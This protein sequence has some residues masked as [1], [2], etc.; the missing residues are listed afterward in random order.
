MAEII[1]SESHKK[2]R[3]GVGRLKKL[4]TRVDLTPMVDLGFLL[5]TFFIFTTVMSQPRA[6]KLVMP[7]D[8]KIEMPVKNSGALTL[9]PAANE[10]VYYYEGRFEDSSLKITSLNGLRDIIMDKKRR[11]KSTDL[12]VIIKPSKACV[13]GNIVK[14]LDEMIIDDIKSYAL[15]DITGKEETLIK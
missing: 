7:A 11:T 6:M 15:V 2:Q 3:R 13:Y 8:S 9:L 14:V 4:S 10:S 12:F 5:I 1:S